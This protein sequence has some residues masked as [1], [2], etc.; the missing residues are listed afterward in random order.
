V[1]VNT[2]A[3]VNIARK[4]KDAS[5]RRDVRSTGDECHATIEQSGTD[6]VAVYEFGGEHTYAL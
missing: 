3:S 1:F 5:S 2:K 4:D 6:F